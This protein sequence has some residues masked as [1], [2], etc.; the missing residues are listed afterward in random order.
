MASSRSMRRSRLP[1]PLSA[2]SQDAVT[3]KNEEALTRPDATSLTEWEEP[4][5]RPP[6]PSFEDYKGLERH[7]VLE[8]MQPLGTLPNQR[9]KLRVKTHD[10]S[11]KAAPMRNGEPLTAGAE[12]MSTPDPAPP[13]PS[14]RSE[15]HKTEDRPSRSSAAREKNE[16]SDYIPNGLANTTPFKAVSSHSSQHGTPSSR[17]ST[18][19]HAKLKKAVEGAITQSN[20]IGN[21]VLGLALQRL[22]EESFHDQN[23]SDLLDAVLSQKPT[24]EQQAGF[25]GYMRLARKEIKRNSEGPKHSSQTKIPPLK[26]FSKS[27]SSNIHASVSTSKATSEVNG[28]KTFDNSNPTSHPY[29]PT[30]SNSHNM[31][32]LSNNASNSD[33]QPPSKRARR[34]NSTSSLS[35]VA[36]SLSSLDP[37]LALQAEEDFRGSNTP[38][39]PSATMGQPR[40]KASA[41]PKMGTFTTSNKRSIAAASLSKEDEELAV[42][43][44]KLQK[45][46]DD[47]TVK[48][49]N[50]RTMIQKSANGAP[51]H[52]PSRPILQ[53]PAQQD[54]RLRIGIGL[55]A[56]DADSDALDSPTTSV[57]SDLLIPPPPFAGSSRRGA[58]PMNLGRPAK[59][60]KKSARVKMS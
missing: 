31:K 5:L 6:A 14:R 60:G 29:S 36:S 32:N 48:N 50:V 13:P 59:P 15:S 52:N 2:P 56:S 18:T 40:S 33:Q 7:G 57:H 45:T 49:S 42:K 21:P 27:P 19:G 37:N 20:E 8:Y 44:R 53:H 22:F 9:V 30:K 39:P 25:Q 46:F 24:K 26:L 35:S 1:T 38:L 16:D 43:R 41:G 54:P 4:P 10:Q 17:A 58:T 34:S 12:D 51:T 47:Y 28:L 23:L 11:R 3:F 55:S